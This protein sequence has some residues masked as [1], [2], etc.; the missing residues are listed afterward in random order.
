MA[1]TPHPK[2]PLDLDASTAAAPLTLAAVVVT[3]LIFAAVAAL[4]CALP[5]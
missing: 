4:V 5:A 1:R 2:L 3:T